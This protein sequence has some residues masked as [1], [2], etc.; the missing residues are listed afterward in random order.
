VKQPLITKPQPPRET[1]RSAINALLKAVQI[2]ER[3]SRDDS[4]EEKLLSAFGEE[5]KTALGYPDT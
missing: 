4:A 1:L 2:Q 5:L 3:M